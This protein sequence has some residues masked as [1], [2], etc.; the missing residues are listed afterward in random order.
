MDIHFFTSSPFKVNLPNEKPIS[1]N[2]KEK[3]LV[4]IATIVGFPFAGVGAV[5]AF[6]GAS[7]LLRKHKFESHFSKQNL[8]IPSS[9]KTHAAV[10]D[11][12]LLNQSLASPSTIDSSSKIKPASPAYISYYLPKVLDGKNA[13][14]NKRQFSNIEKLLQEIPGSQASESYPK[15]K[16]PGSIGIY[17]YPVISRADHEVLTAEILKMKNHYDKVILIR[18]H[19]F[20]SNTYNDNLPTACDAE[21]RFKFRPV[22][23]ISG[24]ESEVCPHEIDDPERVKRLLRETIKQLSNFL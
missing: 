13:D 15:K 8:S 18:C 2:K 9:T 11:R 12:E 22:M 20:T 3:A 10:L 6:F 7:Y 5:F 24:M 17:L 19:Q 4:A 23:D 21:I 1:L 14:L 16:I